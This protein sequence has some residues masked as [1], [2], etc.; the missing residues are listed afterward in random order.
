MIGLD[1][2]LELVV[3]V[4]DDMTQSLA[5]ARRDDREILRRRP[6]GVSLVCLP[7]GSV[8]IY[9]VSAQG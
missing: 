3:L 9:V 2:I 7:A 8:I 5:R 1:R 4:S 6:A